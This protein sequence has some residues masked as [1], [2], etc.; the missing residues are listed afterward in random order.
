MSDSEQENAEQ[1]QSVLGDVIRRYNSTRGKGNKVPPPDKRSITSKANMAKARAAKLE[2]LA[3]D[4]E[5][6]EAKLTKKAAKREIEVSDSSEDEDEDDESEEELVISAKKKTQK[7]GG[8]APPAAAP[9]DDKLYRLE[10]MVMQ[11]AQQGGKKKKKKPIPR[12]KTVIQINQPA[13]AAKTTSKEAQ[14]MKDS[15]C[16]WN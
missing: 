11:L 6:R 7:G 3:A 2:I 12:K 13:P 8:R 10:Q 16:N 14:V 5:V 4:R 9:A 15:L 1:E